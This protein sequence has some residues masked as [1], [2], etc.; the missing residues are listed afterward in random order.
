MFAPLI[1]Q[2][3]L[4]DSAWPQS[5]ERAVEAGFAG[6]ELVI[7]RPWS[8]AA[9]APD[10]SWQS[11]IEAL[12]GPR[13]RILSLRVE[14]SEGESSMAAESSP[15]DGL[16]RWT[17]AG[18]DAARQLGAAAI[19][20]DP[21]ALIRQSWPTGGPDHD[22]T[23]RTAIEALSELRFEAQRRATRIV[24]DPVASRFLGSPSAA[25]TFVDRINSPWVGMALHAGAGRGMTWGDEWV[26]ALG[27]RIFHVCLSPVPDASG[28]GSNS[29]TSK[30][31]GDD[32]EIAN[33]LREARFSG[34]VVVR[35]KGDPQGSYR[36]LSRIWS[37]PQDSGTSAN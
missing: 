27:R 35:A 10:P 24:I 18:L 19:V 3:A 4:D 30:P 17:T 14:L 21:F 7:P 22:L 15:V 26:R 2:V 28:G 12:N 33:A 36:S 13:A 23:I 5:A 25:R 31:M 6:V 8:D 16:I 34:Q 29:G 1:W 32:M 11:M 37:C 9:A 20:I